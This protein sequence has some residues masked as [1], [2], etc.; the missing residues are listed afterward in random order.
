VA[1]LLREL[2]FELNYP[3]RGD[4]AVPPD[5]WSGFALDHPLQPATT[6]VVVPRRA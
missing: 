1:R 4:V 2:I 3:F 6:K 5:L